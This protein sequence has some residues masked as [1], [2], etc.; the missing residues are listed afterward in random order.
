MHVGF[1]TPEFLR[2]GA[3]YPGGLASYTYNVAKE[4]LKEGNQVKVICLGEQNACYLYH[5]ILVIERKN[6]PHR[7][8][9]V[10]KLL[11]FKQI[12]AF[13]DR[14]F[15][16]LSINLFLWRHK[17]RKNIDILHYTSWKAVGAFRVSGA[18]TVRIS[19]FEPL[20]DNNPQKKTLDKRLCRWL[21]AYALRKFDHIFG[22]GKYLNQIIEKKLALSKPIDLLPTPAPDWNNLY[23]YG[24]ENQ[25]KL[26]AYVGTI[27]YIKGGAL[28]LDIIRQYLSSYTDT[29]FICAG[30][31]GAI[32]VFHASVKLAELANAFPDNF[33]Y[34][35]HLNREELYRLYSKANLVIIPSL[36]DNFPNTAL[37][38]MQSGT[39]VLASHS[40]SLDSLIQDNENGYIMSNRDAGSWIKRIRMILY[41]TSPECEISMQQKIKDSLFIHKPQIAV[42]RLLDYYQQVLDDYAQK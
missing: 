26:V 32:G 16:S 31:A 20:I 35:S 33:M 15:G 1:V 8:R 25:K 17:D 10:L 27:S 19:S 36:I 13:I 3:L 41:E 42:G 14:L 4:L 5:G 23:S 18:S 39:P 12:D 40:A 28:L 11:F 21:E 37:E 34:F 29:T 22:P 2:N 30:K 24:A 38:A 7:L 6:F 9:S